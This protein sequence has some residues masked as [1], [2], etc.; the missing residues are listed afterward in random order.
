VAGAALGPPLPGSLAATPQQI[1]VK[2]PPR[3]APPAP[4]APADTQAGEPA[5]PAESAPAD[6]AVAEPVAPVPVTPTPAPQ[7]TPKDK[8]PATPA[9]APPSISHVFVVVLQDKTY[10]QLYGAQAQGT[11]LQS[12][13]PTGVLLSN[14]YAI[15]KGGLPNYVAMTSGQA[16]NA[17]TQSDCATYTDP[18]CVYPAGVRTLPDQLV[19]ASLT[20]KGYVEG[21]E[22]TDP[23][24][25]GCRHPAPGQPD[26]TAQPG[27]DHGYTTHHDPFAYFHS[28]IDQRACAETDVPLAALDADLKDASV[29]PNWSLIVPDLTDGGE[30]ADEF[31]KRLIPKIQKSNAY[32]NGGLIVITTDRTPPPPPPDPNAPPPDPNAPAPP[33]D[34]NAPAPQP[35]PNDPGGGKVGALLISPTLTGGATDD[36]VYTHYSLLRTI[37]DLYRLDALGETKGAKPFVSLSRTRRVSR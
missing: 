8:P 14:Y 12:L 19:A 27:G 35:D 22:R 31:L 34:P 36:T 16:P 13:V 11:Y 37:E 26:P 18:G 10:D 3:P 4:A 6:A 5:A 28:L 1:V 7:T 15:D 33:P 9:P 20:W 30:K 29:T 2:L 24:T 23:P 17:D 21:M 25:A 32:K